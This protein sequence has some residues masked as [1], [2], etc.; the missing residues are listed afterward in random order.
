MA[1]QLVDDV[2]DFTSRESV[3]GK[4]VGNDLREGKIT[5]PLIYA[6]TDAPQSDKQLVETVLAEENYE[7]VPFS[8]ILRVID[9]RNGVARARERATS[10]IDKANAIIAEFPDSPYRRALAAVAELITE[11]DH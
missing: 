9:E 1:F 4:P 11:R 5:L 6:L 7:S 2:L 10:F 8:Q 3:L